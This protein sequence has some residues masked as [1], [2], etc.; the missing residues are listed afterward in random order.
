MAKNVKKEYPSIDELHKKWKES[1]YAKK[2]MTLT[3]YDFS[4]FLLENIDKMDKI[5]DLRDTFSKVYRFIK[6]GDYEK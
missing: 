1:K 6:F 2:D 5:G 3:Q 4:I